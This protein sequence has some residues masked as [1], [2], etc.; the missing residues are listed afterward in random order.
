VNKPKALTFIRKFVPG[1]TSVK[2]GSHPITVHVTKK[3]QD[4]KR[5][6]HD[7]CAFARACRRDQSADVVVIAI[8]T[9]YVVRGHVATR[10]ALPPSVAREIV[11][12]DRGGIFDTGTYRLIP[13][14]PS[15][16]FGTARAGVSH[17]K[18]TNGHGPR[19]QHVTGN[20]RV[21]MRAA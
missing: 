6:D 3:D 7:E 17:A 15:R 4:A 21:S 5:R 9:A 2:D 16:A 20:I 8:A 11:S 14:S 18:S 12:F 19:A 13:P 1:V 10:Y